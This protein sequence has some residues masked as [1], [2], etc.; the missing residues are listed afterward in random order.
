MLWKETAKEWHSLKDK[1]KWFFKE[2]S[3]KI[4]HCPSAL[5]S[6]SKLL[7]NIGSP[8][9]DDGVIWIS[10]ILMSNQDYIDKKPE[11]DTLYYIENIARKFTFNNI[12]LLN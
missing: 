8:Y 2:V 3:E 6:I 11:T 5:Y 12:E 1:D 7:N 9:I 10:N 4:G